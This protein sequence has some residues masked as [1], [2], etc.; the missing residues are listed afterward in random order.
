MKEYYGEW[1][2][3]TSWDDLTLQQLMDIQALYA[4]EEDRHVNIIDI[5]H[6]LTNEDNKIW[7]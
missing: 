2:T 3:P 5:L 6:I 4:N 1:T 7:K